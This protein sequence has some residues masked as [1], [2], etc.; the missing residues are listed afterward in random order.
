MMDNAAYHSHITEM[1]TEEIT[2]RYTAD[3]SIVTVTNAAYVATNMPT[4]PNPAYQPVA[5][6]GEN[7]NIATETNVA[8]VAT[9]IETSVNPS[10][11]PMQNSSDAMLKSMTIYEPVAASQLEYDY[12]RQEYT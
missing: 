8:Y 6:Q 3:V 1:K 11:Q 2:N 4:S 9:D 5:K 7:V 10:Y 12:P